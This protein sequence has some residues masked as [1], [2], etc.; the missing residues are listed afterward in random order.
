MTT[1]PEWE[2]TVLDH[3]YEHV[4]YISL[5]TYYQRQGDDLDTFL[6]QSLAMDEQIETVIA[7]CD[8]I[9]AKKR[10][11]K[12]LMLAFDEWNVWYHSRERDRET[13]RQARW[14]VAPP[15]TEE[16]Y[17]LADAIV[18]G[19]MLISLLKH[20]DRVKIACIAQL[21]NAIAPISTVTGG[22]A[23]RQ[24]TY[25]PYLHASRF[26]RG[27]VLRPHV[28]S[29]TYVNDEFGPVPLLE[30]VVTRDEEAGT[31]TLF[32]V[33]R[34]QAE[35]LSVEVQLRGLPECQVVEH[36]VLA[37]ADPDAT[38][39]LEQPHTVVPHLRDTTRLTDNLLSAQLPP[40]SWNVVRLSARRRNLSSAEVK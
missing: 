26:G 1:Y 10:S 2:T 12:R 40:L 13:I 35:A 17:T 14:A 7:A 18:V 39:T 28:T 23:W 33:N 38:N 19:T 29:P 32:A 9:K 36:L 16:P 37:H 11:P 20:A 21:V 3:V 22:A 34:G 4:D 30:A 24:T 25:Y 8:L 31:L 6:A 27:I 5:H 15:L